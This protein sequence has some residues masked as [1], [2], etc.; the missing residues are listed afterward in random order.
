MISGPPVFAEKFDDNANNW[1]AWGESTDFTIQE[2]NLI[3]RSTQAGQQAMVYC[4]GSCGP[5]KEYYYYEAEMFDERASNSGIGLVF[6]LNGQKNAYY[7][8]K[9]RPSTGEYA[10]FKFQNGTLN[11]LLDWTASPAVLP[12]PQLNILGV[13]FLKDTI[14]LFLNGARINTYQDKNPY[15]EGQIGLLVDQDG[16]RM[17]A[18][19]A[20]V[21]ELVPRTQDPA[22]GQPPAASPPPG[23]T[24]LPGA[25]QPVFTQPSVPTASGPTITPT[26]SGSCPSYVPD[27]QFLLVI[28][29]T[30]INQGRKPQ[31]EINGTVYQLKDLNTPFYLPM[32]QRVVVQTSGQTQEFFISECRVVYVRTK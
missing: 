16:A 6:A 27:G 25:T 14:N 17:M 5:Y 23:A 10:L 21:Y 31:V 4:A 2:G 18:N 12:A 30:D 15:A 7:A 19:E 29:A 11:P 32:N 26:R 13:S 24:P 8:Y 28:T 22:A 3:L 9:V 1:T 20:T